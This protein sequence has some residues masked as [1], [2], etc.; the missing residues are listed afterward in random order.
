[1]FSELASL[2]DH[3]ATFV[4][5]EVLPGSNKGV[6]S[7]PRL[8]ETKAFMA[9]NHPIITALASNA[10]ALDLFAE[11]RNLIVHNAP[12]AETSGRV[13]PAQRVQDC[14]LGQLPVVTLA[15]PGDPKA[16]RE[17]LRAGRALSS[18][19]EWVAITTSKDHQGPDV[20]T[21]SH[22]TLKLLVSIANEVANHSPVAGEMPTIR[23]ADVI[24]EIKR[25]TRIIP[26]LGIRVPGA[27]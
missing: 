16:L 13:I 19:E 14:A 23:V 9:G 12:L 15:L 11:Y 20:L 27:R 18:Y 22:D 8:T 3:L 24:G 7:W 1:M 25:E 6:D 5:R 2:R 26:E 21:Y 17:R 10:P 4:A